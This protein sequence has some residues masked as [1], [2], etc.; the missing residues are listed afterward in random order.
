LKFHSSLFSIPTA[1][2]NPALFF[3]ELQKI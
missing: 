1:P 2:T 3:N